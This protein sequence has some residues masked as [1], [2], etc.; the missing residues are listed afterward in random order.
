[1]IDNLHSMIDTSH[2]EIPANCHLSVDTQLAESDE[3][4]M[5]EA[6]LLLAAGAEHKLEYLDISFCS[7]FHNLPTKFFQL[8]ILK[9]L[10]AF[11]LSSLKHLDSDP[12]ASNHPRHPPTLV[13][14]SSIMFH[15]THWHPS[16]NPSLLQFVLHPFHSE[17]YSWSLSLA[18][19]ADRNPSIVVHCCWLSLL[20][21]SVQHTPLTSC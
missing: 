2:F 21:S 6:S 16:T 4:V 12:T 5:E 18:S 8:S 19:T 15:C 9:K 20:L 3:D 11:R 14:L 10:F 17:N 7:D 1:M 13:I